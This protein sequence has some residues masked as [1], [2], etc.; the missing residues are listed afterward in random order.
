MATQPSRN[1]NS[2]SSKSSKEEDPLLFTGNTIG[3]FVAP[4]GGVTTGAGTSNFTWG[5]GTG[6]PPNSFSF[7]A[8]SFRA[9]P[10]KVFRLGQLAYFNGTTVVGS[11]AGGVQ[12]SLSLDFDNPE[13]GG[14]K[15]RTY[16]LA[17]TSTP[18]NDDPDA[19]ADFVD[20]GTG[21]RL[22]VTLGKR[23]YALDIL[24]FG[25][26]GNRGSTYQADTQF[27]VREGETASSD[28]LARFTS[29]DLIALQ[30]KWN[31]KDRTL[32]Y[33]Y[34]AK[35]TDEL[36][37]QNV[38]VGLYFAKDDGLLGK[39]PTDSKRPFKVEGDKFWYSIPV[40]KLPLKLSNQ[41]L[42]ANRIIAFVD[43]E[44]RISETNEGNNKKDIENFFVRKIP[45]VMRNVGWIKA[46]TFLERWL[47][48]DTKVLNTST[49]KK[50]FSTNPKIQPVRI[51]WILNDSV[52]TN[53]RAQIA[54]DKLK[55]PNYFLSKNAKKELRGKLKLLLSKQ[56]RVKFGNINVKGEALHSQH[57]QNS[58]VSEYIPTLDPLQGAIGNF[59]FY[60][61]PV[62]VA[63]K[64]QGRIEVSIRSVGIY[65]LDT[66]DFNGSQRL[67]NW[68]TPNGVSYIG[69]GT[70]IEN[71]D[72][73]QYR[74]LTGLG[75]DFLTISNVEQ[76]PLQVP[77][78][79]L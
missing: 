54:F 38:E 75:K 63:T 34:Q 2:K 39:I 76:I 52:D 67:G 40:K 61:I 15:D 30:P 59:S 29:S 11:E 22:S 16:R 74:S 65:A 26:V 58:P 28:L 33:G 8:V 45:Q 24:G 35:N 14:I 43:P 71:S 9:Q 20:L 53:N 73:R 78:F 48:G 4:S 3:L 1:S 64:T 23:R 37:G 12:L 60:A 46:A 13:R 36:A 70:S 5:T 51:S 21:R 32:E 77:K 27:R 7:N 47:Q 50:D 79:F 56:D 17:M 18:N 44:D 72:F 31:G 68:Q 41:D 25:R 19:S 49:K 62:G 69:F 6:S 55:D 42:E 10:G 66:F 57:I